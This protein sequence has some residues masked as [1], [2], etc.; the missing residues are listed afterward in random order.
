MS[1]LPVGTY[2]A[3]AVPESAQF[4]ATP[5]TGSEFL[6]VAFRVI[7]DGPEKGKEMP[8]SFWLTP[9]AQEYAIADL[10]VCGCTFPGG[11]ITDMS[12]LGTKEVEIVVQKQKPKDGEVE[13]KYTEIRFINDPHAP[14]RHVPAIGDDKKAALRDRLR[15]A[16]LEAKSKDGESLG[17]GDDIPF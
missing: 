4:G 6:E 17:G 8:R 7:D 3:V 14:R 13:S 9:K 1:H 15:A 12:G 10:R 2:R 11:D 5:T 16:V